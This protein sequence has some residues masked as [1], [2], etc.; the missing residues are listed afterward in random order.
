MVWSPARNHPGPSYPL[1]K[2]RRFPLL[3]LARNAR[4]T[5]VEPIHLHRHAGVSHR[6][7]PEPTA[8]AGRHRQLALRLCNGVITSDAA[9]CT[10]APRLCTFP[11]P[12]G[13]Q[14]NR[15]IS[16]HRCHWI[17]SRLLRFLHCCG[18][19]LCQ[20]PVSNP[21]CTFSPSHPAPH[22]ERT[23]LGLLALQVCRCAHSL[24]ECFKLEARHRGVCSHPPIT[25]CSAD[26]SR[27]QHLLPRTNDRHSGCCQCSWGT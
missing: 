18:D 12:L 24:V 4:Q 2:S 22:P 17:W 8:E 15:C 26:I 14:H 27:R 1:C 3:R 6:A 7:Q 25:N 5:V 19:G 21:W 16:Y 23:S 20:L 9:A 10:F 13:D 11:L